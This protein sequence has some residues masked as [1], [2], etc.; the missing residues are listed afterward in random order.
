MNKNYKEEFTSIELD[1]D[2]KD[3]LLKRGDD[4]PEYAE[5]YSSVERSIEA[6]DSY[7]SEDD[8]DFLKEE[9]VI[10]KLREKTGFTGIGLAGT[11]MM[12]LLFTS[13]NFF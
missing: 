13:I 12:L 5:V 3:L 10:N 4:N 9:E 1:H 11:Q 6:S 8:I 2:I 7:I